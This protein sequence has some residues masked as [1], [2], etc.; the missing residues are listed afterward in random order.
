MISDFYPPF[1]GGV[2]V[3]VSG[4]SRELVRRG[5]DVGVATLAAPGLAARED[6]AGVRVRTPQDGRVEHAGQPEIVD[7]GRGTREEPAIFD[8]LEGLADVFGDSGCRG[9]HRDPPIVASPCLAARSMASMM[10][11]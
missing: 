3:L 8:T 7:V 10:W 6:D 5:H 11:V 4:L 9:A 1:L 2:E